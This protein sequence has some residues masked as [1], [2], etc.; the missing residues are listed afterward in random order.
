MINYYVYLHVSISAPAIFP[1]GPKWIRMNFPCKNL[2]NTV[3]N[4]SI[5]IFLRLSNFKKKFIVN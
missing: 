5:M 2:S 4:L 1:V 3:S